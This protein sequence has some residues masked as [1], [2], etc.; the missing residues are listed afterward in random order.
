M[1][2]ECEWEHSQHLVG[3]ESQIAQPKA[4]GAP[5]NVN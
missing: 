1:F 4:P 5:D 2:S 3:P